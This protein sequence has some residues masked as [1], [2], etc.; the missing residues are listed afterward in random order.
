MS[1]PKPLRTENHFNKLLSCHTLQKN[2][3]QEFRDRE[4]M[5]QDH[6]LPG[7]ESSRIIIKEQS[8]ELS[9]Q[10]QNFPHEAETFHRRLE[11][12]AVY[13]LKQYQQDFEIS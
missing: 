9:A 5:W 10:E 8:L 4:D 13:W 6:N 2:Y 7:A 3:S 11:L 1:K 12:F